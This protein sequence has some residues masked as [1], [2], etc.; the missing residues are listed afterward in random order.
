MLRDYV[1]CLGF[2]FIYFL[3]LRGEVV[4]VEERVF[5]RRKRLGQR[6][7][8]LVFVIIFIGKFRQK[9]NKFLG[10][11]VMVRVYFFCLYF[12]SGEG[13]YGRWEYSSFQYFWKLRKEKRLGSENGGVLITCLLFRM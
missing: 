4:L 2:F 1:Y 3:G 5:K 7:F 6:E 9:D 8:F 10:V 11:I 13:V 12:D